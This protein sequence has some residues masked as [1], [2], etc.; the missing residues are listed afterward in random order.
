MMFPFCE[1]QLRVGS[2][3]VDEEYHRQKKSHLSITLGNHL[4]REFI[5][6]KSYIISA[7]DLW[8][9]Y[10]LPSI[11]Y[12]VFNKTKPILYGISFNQYKL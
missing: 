3:A 10:L 1:D 7:R 4:G 11:V 12:L 9:L 8:G 6:S 5:L 2:A